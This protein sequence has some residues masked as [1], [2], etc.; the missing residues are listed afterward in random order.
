MS[1]FYVGK[2]PVDQ[3][4]LYL[5]FA[6]LLATL[7]ALALLKQL[8]ANAIID[9]PPVAVSWQYPEPEPDLN[10]DLEKTEPPRFRAFRY[11]YKRHIVDVRK[12]DK[13]SWVMLDNE[14]PMYH[15]IKV[16]RLADRGNKIV[17]TMPQAREAAWELCQ[18]LCEFLAR[19]YPQVYNI[20]RSEKDYLG[21]YGLGSVVSVGMP[22][23]GAFYDLTKEDPLTVAGLIQPADLN[24]LMMGEDGQYHLVAMMLGIGGGQRIKDKLGNSLA[25]LH[26]SGHVP[27]YAD[28][29]QRP[30]DRF[31]AK[32]QVEAPFHRNT[33]G[34]S[35]HDAFHWPTVT[36]G[37]EDDW[38]PEIQ[39]PG[40]GTP[41]YGTWKPQGPISDISQ[42][43]FRQERQVLRRLPKS[44]AIVWCVHTYVEPMDV[45]AREPG[46]PGRLASLVRSWDPIMAKYTQGSA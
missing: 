18:D 36:M 38:D 41:S 7:A 30:L 16:Q 15:R 13:D 3:D 35:T 42:L 8:K 5:P 12:L 39:G 23:L 21:W 40:V 28:Q 11:H 26:F 44:R 2:F 29:L 9:K 25:D 6:L 19:R 45:V 32:L 1:F 17:Q 37:P 14:W 27:H 4:Q 20:R 22:S 33:T 46:I 43:W 10:F 31:L 34:I 24:I